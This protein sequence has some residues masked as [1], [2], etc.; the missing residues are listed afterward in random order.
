[1][2]MCDLNLSEMKRIKTHLISTEILQL[3][4]DYNTDVNCLQMI[5]EFIITNCAVT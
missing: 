1:M 3:N 2:L 4:E 5:I